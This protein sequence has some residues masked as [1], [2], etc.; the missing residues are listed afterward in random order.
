MHSCSHRIVLGTIVSLISIGVRCQLV[1]DAGKY[2]IYRDSVVQ[3]KFVASALSSKELSSNYTSPAN[4]FKSPV[5]SF[6]FSINGKDN[7][8]KPGM[9]HSI[10]IAPNTNE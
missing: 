10:V 4:E 1:W 6:K 2:R 5:I 7:E 9:D 8:M 3:G